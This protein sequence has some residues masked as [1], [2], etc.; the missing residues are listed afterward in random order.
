[1]IMISVRDNGVALVL[2]MAYF[3]SRYCEAFSTVPC[4]PAAQCQYRSRPVMYAIGPLAITKKL[5]DPKG[6]NQVV[7]NKMKKDGLTR[8]Q[9][10]DEYNQF[11]E[12][13]PFYY[14]L[15]KKEEYYKS[16]GY[17]DMFDGMIGEAEKE[18]KG[19]EVRERLAK[20]RQQSVLKAAGV[21]ITFVVVFYLARLE[22][23]KD[24][25]SF[26]PGI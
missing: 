10:E 17:K 14:A 21:L 3:G 13:P 24:P 7:E 1:M 11:L 20:F 8:Q 9:A 2:L 22:Y 23:W 6:Y 18:G 15:D 16:L 4:S 26:L 19:D 25:G 12:N 5:A